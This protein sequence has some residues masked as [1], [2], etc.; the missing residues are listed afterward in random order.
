[1]HRLREYPSLRP[2]ILSRGHTDKNEV[3]VNGLST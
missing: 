2:C 1:L 3:G